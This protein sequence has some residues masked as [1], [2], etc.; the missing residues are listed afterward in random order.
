MAKSKNRKQRPN[1]QPGSPQNAAKN[2]FDKAK[3]LAE[4]SAKELISEGIE[5]EVVSVPAS[6]ATHSRLVQANQDALSAKFGYEKLK[7]KINE[8][9]GKFESEKEKFLSESEEVKLRAA[10]L[11]VRLKKFESDLEAF[12]K[13]NEK[14]V[15]L[16]ADAEVGFLS[17]RDE[18]LGPI[19]EKITELSM[20][21]HDG[22]L[23]RIKDW[24]TKLKEQRDLLDLDYKNQVRR[25]RDEE[26]RLTAIELDVVRK[27]NEL[28]KRSNEL[29]IER[30]SL[31]DEVLLFNETKKRQIQDAQ[32][33]A[34]AQITDL[35][36]SKQRLLDRIRDFE[37][38]NKVFDEL[39]QKYQ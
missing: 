16:K 12:Q 7:E 11:D 26:N 23:E 38:N 18:I 30:E 20:A 29:E 10:E 15:A 8:D 22:E 2:E 39:T 31:N 19:Q 34:Q 14:L 5:L 32:R 17:R 6:D 9:R 35:E 25:L 1:P 24:S 3:S 36:E 13:E 37:K 21:W 33:E 4:E 28:S 27:E